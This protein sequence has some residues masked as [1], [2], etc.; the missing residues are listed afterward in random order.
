MKYFE[1]GQVVQE[2]PFKDILDFKL[3]MVLLPPPPPGNFADIS[4]PEENF[5]PHLLRDVSTLCSGRYTACYVCYCN[6]LR[7]KEK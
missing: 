4:Y 7:K 6:K 1:F 5:K 2:M 3:K